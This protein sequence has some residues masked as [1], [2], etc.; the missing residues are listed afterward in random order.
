MTNKQT[1]HGNGL[2]MRVDAPTQEPL[3]EPT[4]TISEDKKL[5]NAYE[6]LKKQ[7]DNTLK[8]LAE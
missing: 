6:K 3:Q 4:L 8:K 2:A 5:Q 7:Y 1:K